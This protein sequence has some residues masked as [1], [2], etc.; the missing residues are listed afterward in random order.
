[1][2]EYFFKKEGE[3]KR[4]EG[5]GVREEIGEQRENR[6]GEMRWRE[7]RGDTVR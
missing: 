7:K 5:R 6:R 4:G 2:I 3:E 1:M